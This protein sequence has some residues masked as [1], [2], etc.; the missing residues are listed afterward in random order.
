MPFVI[1]GGG[2]F[3]G[4]ASGNAIPSPFSYKVSADGQRLELWQ[5]GQMIAV[6]SKSGSWFN[7]NISTGVGSL[8][9]GGDYSGGLAHSVSSTGQ[10][11]GFKNEFSRAFPEDRLMFFPCW[12]GLSIDN[13]ELIPATYLSFSS[14][15]AST[16]NGNVHAS[17]V[18]DYNFT[19][20]ASANFVTT[21]VSFWPAE[22]YTG[23]LKNIIISTINNVEIYSTESDVV[24]YNGVVSS[25]SYKYPFFLRQGDGVRLQLIKEDG[26]Y[27]RVRAGVTNSSQPWRELSIRTYTDQNILGSNNLTLTGNTLS[28][29]TTD[30]FN[31]GSVSNS[32]RTMHTQNTIYVNNGVNEG[33]VDADPNVLGVY[34]TTRLALGYG[35]KAQDITISNEG[36]RL[37]KNMTVSN[38]NQIRFEDGDSTN[39]EAI[40][41]RMNGNNLAFYGVLNG[42][43][44]PN[45]IAQLTYDGTFTARNI[46]GGSGGGFSGTDGKGTTRTLMRTGSTT[47][48]EWVSI[49]EIP[50]IR[51][52]VSRHGLRVVVTDGY[53]Y[54]CRWSWIE[55]DSTG[56]DLL[57]TSSALPLL[58]PSSTHKPRTYTISMAG[59][60]HQA[61]LN[62]TAYKYDS[63]PNLDVHVCMS[64][65]SV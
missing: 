63:P 32:F 2:S 26:S 47:F 24:L 43:E 4:N 45:P 1:G 42:V 58:P 16:P 11:V 52:E 54:F 55:T 34:A 17:S 61:M 51:M 12:Q 25:I 40:H 33:N 44:D 29:V 13:D 59:S 22:N 56:T 30:V 46:S 20:T 23:K 65:N 60:Y 18:V 50:P 7:D 57:T 62:I 3:S 9:L 6:Q 49:C 21:R 41:L 37:N 39:K 31:F 27:L 28:P 36:V 14:K 10:N 64:V 53:P 35:N 38:G 48:E 8:H 19:I 5:G 15:T